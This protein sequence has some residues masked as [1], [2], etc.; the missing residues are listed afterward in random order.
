MGLPHT[1]VVLRYGAFYGPGT[2]LGT[3][4]EMVEMVRRRKFPV[5]GGGGGMWSFV[6]IDDA[7]A[8]TQLAVQRGAPGLYNIA[9]DEPAPVSEWLPYLAE[10]VGAKKPMRLPVWIARPMVGRHGVAMMTTIRGSSNAKAKRELGWH[11]TYPS[12]R[13]GFRKL[14]D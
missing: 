8:A 1:G 12:W 5:V 10:A 7:A 3:G 13:D 14:A 9:D 11:P 2:G 4:G 6:H